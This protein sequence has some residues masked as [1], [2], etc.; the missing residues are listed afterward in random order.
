M[1]GSSTPLSTHSATTLFVSAFGVSSTS[2]A[3][4][5]SWRT[6]PGISNV[7]K[8][9][10]H[11]LE[12]SVMWKTEAWMLRSSVTPL[13]STVKTTTPVPPST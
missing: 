9:D 11:G 3:V 8:S 6:S 13:I 12:L 4:F 5:S 2:K 7:W 1:S 10:V